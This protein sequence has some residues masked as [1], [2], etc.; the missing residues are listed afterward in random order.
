MS[1]HLD[2]SDDA[3]RWPIPVHSALPVQTA[4]APLTPPAAPAADDETGEEEHP[5]AE[6]D[7]AD[8]EQPAGHHGFTLPD[9]RPYYDIRPLAELG[10]FAV[11]VTKHTAPPLLRLLGRFL[12]NLGRMLAWYARGISVLLALAAAW[13]SGA[14]G[15]Q[16]SVGAR[17]A[18]AGFVL[19]SAYKLSTEYP[20]APYVI[21]ALVLAGVV[22]AARGDIK[23][24]EQKAPAK[25]GAKDGK[26]KPK[27]K[28]AGKA[29][30]QTEESPVDVEEEAPADKPRPGLLARP[31]ARRPTPAAATSAQSP[32]ESSAEAGEE[33]D[34]EADEAPAE[35]PLTA[36]IRKE[37]GG[38]NGVHLK[39][40]RPAMRRALPALSE[41]TDEELRATLVRAGYDPSKKFRARGV[42]GR[43]GVPRTQL[44]PLPS[45]GDAPGPLVD[46]SPGGGDRLPPAN[47]S[48]S[49][50]PRRGAG[51]W[52]AEDLAR[53]WRWVPDPNGHPT[54]W[55]I[56]H[57]GDK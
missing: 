49:G 38:E 28:A 19:Y 56:E 14:I 23:A 27:G 55:Q 9:L 13:L 40:L 8:D 31:A 7:G 4:P 34:E 21:L 42:A 57:H 18:G 6:D 37:I 1:G 30:A 20:A 51:E 46:H 39:D 12:R 5:A 25:K 24:P 53:G 10:P 48:A 16:G 41:A 15:K 2:D 50:E 52:T 47:S 44:P 45:P 36:L 22:L 54:A 26:A 17:L 29:S 11:Q 35:D 33:D 32:V 3:G 43:A